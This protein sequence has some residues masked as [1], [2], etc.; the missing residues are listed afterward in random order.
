MNNQ[1]K[2]DVE[3]LILEEF[4]EDNYEPTE[5]GKISL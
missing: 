2:D 4:D 1:F 5:E 3:S